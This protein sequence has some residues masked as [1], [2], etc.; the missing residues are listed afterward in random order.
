MTDIITREDVRKVLIKWQNDLL[1][2]KQVHDWAE[3]R[4]MN[5]QFECDDWEGEEEW[6][7]TNEVLAKLDTLN[8]NLT[9]ADDVSIFMAFLSTPIGAF[10]TGYQHMEQALKSIDIEKRK[11]QLSDIDFYR[12][13]CR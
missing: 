9:T 4:Y 1:S 3:T 11:E 5:S 12:P 10:D 7:V 2:A 8:M 6:S 13:F